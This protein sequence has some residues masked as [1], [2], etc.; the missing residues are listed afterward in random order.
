MLKTLKVKSDYEYSG[1]KGFEALKKS[2]KENNIYDIVL[3]DLNMPGMD[4]LEFIKKSISSNYLQ[5]KYFVLTGGTSD[6]MIE[7]LIKAGAEQVLMKPITIK[8]LE[9][10]I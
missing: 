8:T 2:Y 6:N 10:V 4:G 5:T 7:T 3:T 1:I 9:R